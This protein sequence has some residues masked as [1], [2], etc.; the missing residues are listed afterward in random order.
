MS[1][2]RTVEELSAELVIS[3]AYGEFNDAEKAHYNR[4][5]DAG[6]ASF[7]KMDKPAR[8]SELNK[9]TDNDPVVYKSDKGQVFRKSDDPRFVEMAK[10]N[11]EN[12]RQLK[13]EREDRETLEFEKRADGEFKTLPGEKSAKVALLK[14]VETI[15]DK[16]TREKVTEILKAQAEAFK[17]SLET[18]GSG[19]SA[20]TR[21][22]EEMAKAYQKEHP[23]KSYEEA[24]AEVI[25]T[26]DGQ[27]LY[28]QSLS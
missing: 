24:Y 9:A 26:P 20:S 11:D 8:E 18:R 4:L 5:D 27:R 15:G 21:S 22:L 12:A 14:A 17:P 2:E 10:E 7:L 6:K 16:D 13:K 25:K 3:K 23:T 19:G 1:K 28:E